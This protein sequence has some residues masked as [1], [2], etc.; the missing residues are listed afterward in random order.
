M[1]TLVLGPVLVRNVPRHSLEW[2]GCFP[3]NQVAPKM[4]AEYRTRTLPLPTMRVSGR[5]IWSEV[6][7][8]CL[9]RRSPSRPCRR[10]LP[11]DSQVWPRI[12]GKEGEGWCLCS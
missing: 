3:K 7:R 11:G 12:P 10:L 4:P 5:V 6:E 1:D 2:E 9:P 8:N